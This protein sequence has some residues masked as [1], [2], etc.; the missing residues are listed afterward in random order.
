VSQLSTTQ[1]KRVRRSASK[2]VVSRNSHDRRQNKFGTRGITPTSADVRV[3]RVTRVEIRL[4]I[5]EV[6]SHIFI[7][8]ITDSL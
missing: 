4:V 8:N 1:N 7:L 5:A 2:A 3:T 6:N